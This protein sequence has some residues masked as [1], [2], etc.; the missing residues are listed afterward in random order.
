MNKFIDNK[1]KYDEYSWKDIEKTVKGNGMKSKCCNAP[2]YWQEPVKKKGKIIRLGRHLCSECDKPCFV[3]LMEDCEKN[4]RG[5][6]AE[7]EETDE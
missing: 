5:C 4:S 7:G 2:V 3:K 6:L 1:E